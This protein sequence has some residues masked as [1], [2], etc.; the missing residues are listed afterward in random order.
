M[1]RK[2]KEQKGLPWALNQGRR[3]NNRSEILNKKFLSFLILISVIVL[4]NG[5]NY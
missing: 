4:V 3:V 2:K 1:K 5:T